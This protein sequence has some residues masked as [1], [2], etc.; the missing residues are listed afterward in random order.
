MEPVKKKSFRVNTRK[1][2]Y[3]EKI[4]DAINYNNYY[5]ESN[6]IDP[7]EYAKEDLYDAS[8]D[9]KCL[10]CDDEKIMTLDEVTSW[11]EE[12]PENEY[13]LFECSSCHEETLV[14]ESIYEEIKGIKK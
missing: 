6:Y 3:E 8:V 11:L 12:H 7:E 14:P 13:P 9:M 5:G 1:L 10:N 2:S 4:Q